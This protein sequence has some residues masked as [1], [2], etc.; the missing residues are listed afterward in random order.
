MPVSKRTPGTLYLGCLINIWY[1]E[2][3]H[4]DLEGKDLRVGIT[5]ETRSHHVSFD[6]D[7]P[8]S[9]WESLPGD[10]EISNSTLICSKSAWNQNNRKVGRK[11]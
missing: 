7:H 8:Q 1:L 9:K 3:T 4:W 10:S 5:A 11:S 6:N 2:K